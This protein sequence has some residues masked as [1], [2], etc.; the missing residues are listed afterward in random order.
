M[1]WSRREKLGKAISCNKSNQDDSFF[2]PESLQQNRKQLLMLIYV[3]PANRNST[4]SVYTSF[5]VRAESLLGLSPR[6]KEDDGTLE[7]GRRVPPLPGVKNGE[8]LTYSS[9]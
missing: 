9:T 5:S 4:H 7:A 8:I 6:P 2:L 1:R 3:S